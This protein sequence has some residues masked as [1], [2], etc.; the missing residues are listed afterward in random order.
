MV[1]T[2]PN[3][4]LAKHLSFA[5]DQGTI[6]GIRIPKSPPK[7]PNFTRIFIQNARTVNKIIANCRNSLKV[8]TNLCGSQVEPTKT[9][10]I[11]N[12]NLV[13]HVV[14]GKSE[15]K[16]LGYTF[17]LDNFS[18]I[19]ITENQFNKR[20]TEMKKVINDIYGYISNYKTRLAIFNI[21]VNPVIEFFN[22]KELFQAH[23]EESLDKSPL[24]KFQHYCL[25]AVCGIP[26]RATKKV[27]L[28]NALKVKSVAEKVQRFSRSLSSFKTVATKIAHQ[29]SKTTVLTRITRQHSHNYYTVD[30]NPKNSI[31]LKIS[32][33]SRKPHSNL[34]SPKP[35]F[36]K[37]AH[38]I[39]ALKKIRK[40]RIRVNTDKVPDWEQH[41][42][43]ETDLQV[44][45]GLFADA[46]KPQRT[47]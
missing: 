16:W 46:L 27:D 32:L 6:I 19:T 47:S 30:N 26:T 21:W 10:I 18:K 41:L 28:R 7:S 34:K 1:A 11:V 37:L 36:K 3:V 23:T 13:K 38:A 17:A 9:E 33:F 2:D 15:W 12:P 44:H 8:A 22:L 5:D 20:A 14:Q 39:E 45:Y 4:V 42:D 29:K 24:E 31:Y 43:P 35:V 40:A 25:A